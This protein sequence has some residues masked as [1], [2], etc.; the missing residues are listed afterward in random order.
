MCDLSDYLY[1]VNPFISSLKTLADMCCESDTEI[2][3]F[4]VKDKYC[5]RRRNNDAIQTDVAAIFRSEDGAPP[6][7]RNLNVYK[8]N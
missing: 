6:R 2:F 4:I 5:D 1:F 3:M 7:D 8:I